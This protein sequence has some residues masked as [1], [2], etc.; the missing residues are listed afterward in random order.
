MGII[1]LRI[2]LRALRHAINELQAAI[3]EYS[4]STHSAQEAHNKEQAI[5]KPV[6][7][8]VYYGQQA[9]KDQERYYG[10]QEGIRKWTRNAVIAAVIY[11]TIAAFQ[12]SEMR[13]ATEINRAALVATQ[14]AYVSVTG[15]NIRQST[16]NPKLV[17]YIVSPI[18][19]NSGNT[20]TKN[21]WWTAVFGIPPVTVDQESTTEDLGSATHNYGTLGARQEVRD[22]I[23]QPI[24]TEYADILRGSYARKH[25]P[26]FGALVYEDGMSYPPVIH[27]RRYC[28][29][30]YVNP[31]FTPPT[32]FSYVMCGGRSNCEDEECDAATQ[33]QMKKIVATKPN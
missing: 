12:Y 15:L 9:N 2:E 17:S 23:E 29:S 16:F 31:Y 10:T 28:Y 22:L 24:P 20:P 4:E 8:T 19:V 6:P 7:V 5:P 3:Q 33:E 25:I 14:R 13:K 30:L 18:V 26:V 1:N 32:S 11:A 21:L 27:V